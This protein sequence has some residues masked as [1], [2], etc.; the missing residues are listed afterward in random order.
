MQT[1]GKPDN[2]AQRLAALS[3]LEI[4]DESHVQ[5]L[6]ELAELAAELCEVPLSAISLIDENRQFFKASVGL[7][8]RSTSRDISFCGHAILQSEIFVVEDAHSD[9]RFADNPLVQHE[10]NVRFYAGMPL[11]TPR[12]EALGTLCVL[13]SKARTLSPSQQRA[14]KILAHQAAQQLELIR[15]LKREQAWRTLIIEETQKRYSLSQKM[16]SMG[17]MVHDLHHELRNLQLATQ[18]QI[19]NEKKRFEVLFATHDLSDIWVQIESKLFKP[20]ASQ[21]AWVEECNQVVGR[22]DLP[23]TQ[24][25]FMLSM[26]GVGMPL[27][28]V[29]VRQEAIQQLDPGYQASIHALFGVLDGFLHMSDG[30]QRLSH[31]T[32]SLLDQVMNDSPIGLHLLSGILESSLSIFAK[33]A[34]SLGVQISSEVDSAASMYGCRSDLNHILMNVFKNSFEA[35]EK[36]SGLKGSRSLYISHRIEEQTLKL[37]IKDN[38]GGIP[39]ERLPG[40]FNPSE[41]IMKGFHEGLG[42]LVAQQIAHKNA[43]TLLVESDSQGTTVQISMPKEEPKGEAPGY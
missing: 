32:A 41:A 27:K 23:A 20:R 33:R 39:A 9:P 2:E 31:L 24:K 22:R 11:L 19:E 18:P 13:D 8:I 5:A 37:I 28:E 12:Q 14:L 36:T 1:P 21:T 30:A 34:R 3:E 42:L 26:L 15:M 43:W 25:K 4:L 29:Q 38:A 6:D 17:E 16:A 7:G 10:P 35:F 40:L